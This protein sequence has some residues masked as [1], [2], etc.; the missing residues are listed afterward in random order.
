MS[1]FWKLFASIGVAMGVTLTAAVYVS[2][3][4]ASATFNQINF[5]GR[6]PIIREAAAALAER[7][8]RGLRDWLRDQARETPRQMLLLVVDENGRGEAVH[9]V[10]ELQAGADELRSRPPHR[11]LEPLDLQGTY[12]D[13]IE[14]RIKQDNHLTTSG[15]DGTLV[16][17]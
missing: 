16:R 11:E 17:A 13:H 7:G 10:E 9:T 15:Y 3:G 14:E 6:E 12:R 1:L 4:I 5:E 8:E 2:Y